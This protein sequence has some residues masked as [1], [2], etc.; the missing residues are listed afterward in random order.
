MKARLE[1]AKNAADAACGAAA[2]SASAAADA[3]RESASA[4]ESSAAAEL[5]AARA[6]RDAAEARAT[7][8]LASAHA[9]GKRAVDAETSVADAVQRASEAEARLKALEE[10]MTGMSETGQA[11]LA[12]LKS[13]LND[14]RKKAMTLVAENDAARDENEKLAEALATSTSERQQDAVN[15]KKLAEGLVQATAEKER[16]TE[17][18]KVAAGEQARLSSEMEALRRAPPLPAPSCDESALREQI[19]NL[20]RH[21]HR[22]AEERVE[23]LARL[24]ERR[25]APPP[26]MANVGN[27]PAISQS[28]PEDHAMKFI[29][30]SRKAKATAQRRHQARRV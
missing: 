7:E 14:E 5:Q 4:L 28:L 6:A 19:A 3:H 1:D 22:Q 26:I 24:E 15:L 9:Y 21:V 25:D 18:L 27:L 2:S 29:Q 16:L 11:E 30:R 13:R 8:A 17:L 23:L 12:K 10:A 20:E